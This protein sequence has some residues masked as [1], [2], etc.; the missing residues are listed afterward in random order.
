MAVRRVLDSRNVESI[1]N[2]TMPE[3]NDLNLKHGFFLMNFGQNKV[4]ETL[5]I[6]ELT[7]L[8]GWIGHFTT[9]NGHEIIIP[10]EGDEFVSYKITSRILIIS[11]T[12]LVRRICCA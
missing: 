10:R 9:Y 2:G 7:S 11:S 4:D 3:I 6:Q 12:S 1:L 8:C 5:G